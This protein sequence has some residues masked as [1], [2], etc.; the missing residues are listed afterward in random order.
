MVDIATRASWG[1]KA[2]DGDAAAT[3][4][5]RDEVYIHTSVTAHLPENATVEQ[6]RAQMRSLESIGVN[7][8]F[9]SISYHVCV[10]PSGRA[11]WGVSRGRRGA[12]VAGRNSRAFGIVFVGNTDTN[13]ASQAALNTVRAIIAQ[14]RGV[15]FA[16]GAAVYP[17][18]KVA[19]KAC[20][21]KYVMPHMAWLATGTSAP[22][23][24][25]VTPA[26]PKPSTPVAVTWRPVAKPLTLKQGQHKGSA[27]VGLWQRILNANGAKLKVDNSFGAATRT[28]TVAWQSKRGLKPD[29]VVGAA[30]WTR[31]LTADK[32][33]RL[34]QGDTGPH[35]WLWQWIIGVTKAGTFAGVFGPDTVKRTGDVQQALRLS[36]D[37]VVGTGTA[38]GVKARMT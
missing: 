7:R 8:G 9:G 38:N 3:P 24:K 17:H 6:E 11:Y 25:P 32:D 19:A 10:F 13:P 1:A 30:T 29:G 27:W 16:K 5:N 4:L 14:E 23:S 15:S 33:G 22:V 18:N 28:A 36:A 12:H 20:P 21:G 26:A 2:R 31:A 35:V 34:R 37:S